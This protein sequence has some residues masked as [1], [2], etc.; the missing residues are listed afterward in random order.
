MVVGVDVWGINIYIYTERERESKMLCHCGGD[1]DLAWSRVWGS[2]SGYSVEVVIQAPP[3]S[4]LL[5]LE[6]ESARAV[7]L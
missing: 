4:N 7:Q 5:N 1:V 2:D 6:D 3:T